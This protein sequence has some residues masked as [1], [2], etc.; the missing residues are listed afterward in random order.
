L[1]EHPNSQLNSENLSSRSNDLL[2]VSPH[3]VNPISF[4]SKHLIASALTQV[5]NPYGIRFKCSVQEHPQV[6][7]REYPGE[8][9]IGISEPLKYRLRVLCYSHKSLDYKLL[10]EPLAK[11][12]RNLNLQGFQDA[13]VQFDRAGS[14]IGESRLR[15]DLTPSAAILDDWARWGDVQ[16]IAKLL[17]LALADEEIQVNIILKNLVLHIFCTLD[18]PRSHKTALRLEATYPTRK[19]AV[20]LITTILSKLS[21]QGIQGATIYGL[22][23]S[24]GA[25]V[26]GSPIWTHW[27]DLPGMSNPRFSPTPLILAARGDKDALKFV[28]E[29]FLNPD[30][31]QYCATG[32]IGLSILRRRRVLHIMS[33]ASTCPIQSQVVSISLKIL[34]QLALPDIS[35]VRIYGRI[36]GQ[37]TPQW[38][39]GLD[40]DTPR[41]ELPP[42]ASQ[43]PSV[44]PPVMPKI[45]RWE[46][47]RGHLL[48]TGIW[49]PQLKSP[50]GAELSTIP[51]FRWEPSLLLLGVGLVLTIATDW[52]LAMGIEAPAVAPVQLTQSQSSKLSFNNPLLE[53]KL[54][55]YQRLCA[56]Q[57]VPDVLIVGSSRALRGVDPDGLRRSLQ[58]RGLG[59]LQI[60]NFGIN[61]ATARTVDLLLRQILTPQ[62]LPKL[63]IWADGARAFNSG[64]IDRTYENI[65]S[66]NRYRQSI[67]MSEGGDG[68]RSPLFLIQTAVKSSYEAIDSAVGSQFAAVSPL[69]HHRDLLKTSLQTY[70]PSMGELIQSKRGDS[71]AD[72]ITEQNLKPNVDGFLPLEVKFDPDTYYQKY[73]KVTGGS[74]GDYSNFQLEGNQSQ[75]VQEVADLLASRKIPLVFVNLPMTDI[76]LDKFRRDRET[77]FKKYMQDLSSSNQLTFVDLDGSLNTQYD[78]FSDPSHLNRFGGTEVSIQLSKLPSIPWRISK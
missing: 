41:L 74:D 55:R 52:L 59:D 76:Y 18:K 45:S 37:S 40:F 50:T 42:V 12:L 20:D 19:I 53:Q 31:E 2:S 72:G 58:E 1:P 57:G 23:T 66:S 9:K 5:L 28:V 73:A 13:I 34:R 49:E 39:Y 4:D 63:V 8:K 70:I 27:L 21:P 47:L 69:Y 7:Q 62:Q 77:E 11:G 60:Y 75:A 17:N 48:A 29:R 14:Q 51:R 22:K 6:S 71:N 67:L 10:A 16:S 46:R 68:D 43:P 30:L 65:V 54:A 56:Q 32:G 25:E 44:P 61:G 15:L 3:E 36:S 33:D 64:R 35:G 38:T 24:S 26:P 78:L